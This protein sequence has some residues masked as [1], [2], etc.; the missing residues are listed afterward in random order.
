MFAGSGLLI[1]LASCRVISFVTPHTFHL[2][3]MHPVHDELID[4]A[5][6]CRLSYGSLWETF[7]TFLGATCAF[8]TCD[9]VG[10]EACHLTFTNVLAVYYHCRSMGV[11]RQ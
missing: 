8:P 4:D 2:S 5:A 3:S 7:H 1:F 9:L 6:S 10:P 11:T